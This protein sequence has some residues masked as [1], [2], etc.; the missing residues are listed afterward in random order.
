MHGLASQGRLTRRDFLRTTGA[1]AG[2]ALAARAGAADATTALPVDARLRALAL[3]APL[4]LTFKGKTAAD[5]NAWQA[6][7]RG[8]LE[9]LLGAFRPP[10]SWDSTLVREVPAP[11]HVREEWLVSA[12]GIAAV[13]VHLLRPTAGGAAAGKRAG[14]LALHGHSMDH[15]S[16]AGVEEN[17]AAKA[18]IAR[19]RCDYGLQLVRRGYVVAAPCLTPFGPRLAPKANDARNDACETTHLRLQ[20]LGRSLLGE[21]L[22]D[23]LWA[24]EFLA[25]R[26]EVDPGRL[27]CVGLSLGGRMATF[28]AALDSRVKV[29]VIAG[30]LNCL[31]ERILTRSIG[32]C[33]TLP[34]LLEHG[35]MPEVAALAAPWTLLWTVGESDKLINRSW[36]DKALERMNAVYRALG[37]A[38]QLQVQ[39][40]AGGHEWNGAVAY[41]LLEHVLRR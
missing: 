41:P 9:A 3:A 29:A 23:C 39:R 35:D 34:G 21:N 24:L 5:A 22:R 12:S 15:D 11:D 20:L 31:Q 25:R 10:A 4:A 17:P 26:S 1:C 33:Q 40:F 36:A 2:Y 30:A 38:D 16:I 7:F 13:P 27:G 32:G 19:F 28:V 6:R 18:A 14:I 8:Q 37:A